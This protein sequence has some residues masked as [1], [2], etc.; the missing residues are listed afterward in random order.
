MAK[1]HELKKKAEATYRNIKDLYSKDNLTEED[2][3][4]FD[5]WNKEFDSLMAQAKKY[6]E[7]EKKEIEESAERTEV[8]KNLKPGDLTPE[9]Q[10]EVLNIA[11]KEYYLKGSISP[12]ARGLFERAKAEKDDKDFITK[13]YEKLG[14]TR[15]AQQST[16]DGSGGYTIP[17]GFQ[18]EL[19]KAM[20]AY[21]GMQE[22]SRIWR[23]T[24]GNTVDWPKINDTANRA[25]LIGEAVNAETSAVKLTDANQQFE[26]YK[27]TSGM[28]RLSSEI[29]EDSAFDM[30]S[31][32][33]EFLAERMGRGINYYATL[34]DGSSKPKGITIAAAHGN[35]T[36]NDTVLEASDFLAL[37]HEV[38]PAYRKTARF[39]F[40]DTT[41]KEIKRIS[42]TATTLNPLWLPSF[43]DG[44][45]ATIL[46]YQYTINQDM[47]T[48]TAGAGSANDSAKLVLFGDFKKFIIRYVNRMRMVRLVERFG[49][50]DE[51]ALC[52]FWRF[53]SDLLDAGTHPV[54]YMRVSAT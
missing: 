54:K 30:V 44:A 29:V 34:A 10:R 9:K 17:T 49:D 11:L 31:I 19:E 28:L 35:N 3:K 2:N 5:E 21:G 50:T 13:E 25:Y 40:H 52:A 33:N 37:E 53:D 26:A 36:A 47:A 39:M 42:V 1:S 51:I 48:F 4:K 15:A 18:S 7:F 46:G 12:E 23:T 20:L 8:E 24:S 45:P 14:M 38:D 41:L 16:T 6:E 22:V 27:I 32:V 43:R